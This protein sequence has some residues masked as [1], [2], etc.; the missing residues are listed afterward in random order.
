[1]VTDSWQGEA[2]WRTTDLVFL[3]AESFEIAPSYLVHGVYDG[4]W[5]ALGVRR[6]QTAGGI[7]V[8]PRFAAVS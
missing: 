6:R 7:P 8:S 2:G 5:S 4:W 3:S 1:M